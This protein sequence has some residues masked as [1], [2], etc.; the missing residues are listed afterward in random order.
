MSIKS[1][2]EGQALT[3]HVFLPVGC[4]VVQVALRGRTF[5]YDF[6]RSLQVDVAMPAS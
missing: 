6:T 4:S 3:A 5:G 1:W 2:E